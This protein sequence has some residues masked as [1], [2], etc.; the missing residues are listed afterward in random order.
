MDSPTSP[1]ETSLAA[2][3][4][5]GGGGRGPGGRLPPLRP[6]L[7]FWDNAGSQPTTCTLRLFH[8]LPFCS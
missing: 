3:Q 8:L 1:E 2:E 6:Q 7:P 5:P 4:W